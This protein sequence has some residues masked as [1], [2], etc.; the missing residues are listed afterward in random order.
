MCPIGFEG[1]NCEKRIDFCKIYDPCKNGASCSNQDY[2]NS[3]YKCNCAK[4]EVVKR[5]FFL[6]L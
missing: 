2:V 6:K 4:G 3:F 1:K 5:K